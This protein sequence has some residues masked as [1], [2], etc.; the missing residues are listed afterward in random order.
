MMKIFKNELKLKVAMNFGVVE[1]R[2][3]PTN[4]PTKE[5]EGGGGG[6]NDFDGFLKINFH[7]IYEM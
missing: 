1:I 7:L 5:E 4:G 2:F 3:R 6:G